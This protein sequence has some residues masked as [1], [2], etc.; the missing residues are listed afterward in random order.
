MST[1]AQGAPA[2]P[3]LQTFTLDDLAPYTAEQAFPTTASADFRVF[4]VGRDDVHGVLMHLFTRVSL[5]VKMNMFGYDDQDLNNVLMGLVDNP[6]VMVQVTLDRSQA[7]CP[8]E[9]AILSSDHGQDAQGYAN[10]FAVGNS[11]TDQ[12][13]HTKGGVLDGIVAFEGSTNWSSSGEGTGIN[14]TA[15]KQ[16]PGFKA[17]NNTLAVYVNPYEI[18]KFAARLDYEHGVAY[19]QPQPTFTAGAPSP[20]AAASSATGES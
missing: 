5:S 6:S 10:D 3:T 19:S 12:I 17:Q 2:H 13:S 16:A 7:S 9:K 15:A 1:D 8:T 4:Y 18:A 14:L 11:P 20:A